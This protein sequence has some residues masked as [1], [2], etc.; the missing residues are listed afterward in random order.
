[1]VA[2][3][4]L[5]VV[6]TVVPVSKYTFYQS[7]ESVCKWLNNMDQV[8][9]GEEGHEGRREEWREGREAGGG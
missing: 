5:R 7:L 4:P 2:N 1:M 8:T 9:E 6:Q 3:L